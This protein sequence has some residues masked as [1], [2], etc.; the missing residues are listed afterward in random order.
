M[1]ANDSYDVSDYIEMAYIKYRSLADF[2]DFFEN[3]H[4]QKNRDFVARQKV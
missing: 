2:N 3:G 1:V 4:F